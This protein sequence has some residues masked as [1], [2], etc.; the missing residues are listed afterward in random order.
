MKKRVRWPLLFFLGALSAANL[1]ATEP[2]PLL[3]DIIV[4][5]TDL[6]NHE[7]IIS[8]GRNYLRFSNGTANIGSGALHL[9]G[10]FP[11]T[12]EG[13]QVV[14][15]RVFVGDDTFFD[16]DAGF[17]VFHP[18]HSHIHIEDW[19]RYRLREV[20]PDG[21][22]GPIIRE[23]GK[24]SFCI[25]DLAIYDST[26]PGFARRGQYRSCGSTIQG[27]SVGWI[28]IY[29][30]E[31]P[32]QNIEITDLP[33]GFYWLESEVDPENNI[34]ESDDDNN[35]A[36]IQVT[37]G[38]PPSPPDSYEPN[39]TLESVD[40][41]PPG[42]PNSSNLGPTN[43]KRVLRDMSIHE[44]GDEDYFKF[45]INHRGS[46]GDFVR[47]DFSNSSGNLGL[48]LLNAEGNLLGLSDRN[49]HFETIALTGMEEGWY[50]A[51]VFSASGATNA[52]YM[53]TVVPPQNKAPSVTLI[54]PP[55]GDTRLVHGTD[56][57]AVTWDYSDEEGNLAWVNVY[58]NTEPTF[59]GN[60]V[61]L[62]TALFT[63]AEHGLAVVNS[64]ELEPQTYW[65]YGEI[66]DGGSTTGAW[67]EGT[68]TFVELDD[69][70]SAN[71]FSAEDCNGNSLRDSC[72]IESG[73][74]TDCNWNGL[75]D[76]C[77]IEQG[78][79]VDVDGNGLADECEGP[80]FHR[81][82]TNHDGDVDVADASHLFNFLFLT[83][84][85]PTCMEAADC[86]N[87]SQ[88]DLTDGI[89]ILDFLFLGSSLLAAPGPTPLPC[90]PDPD[91][92]GEA[93]DLGCE[94]YERC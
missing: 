70:C 4:R 13:K 83:G 66:T 39:N 89:L 11:E 26:L 33:D 94:L 85:S 59:D 2:E 52:N 82:D 64:A 16:I 77:D 50:F 35:I 88:V 81:G 17:F 49:G 21:G 42:L 44:I 91:P 74:R 36:R 27:L 84:R 54:T 47:I 25:L 22:V 87:S 8:S 51:R 65:V 79:F 7:T 10:V 5:S 69:T 30:K 31:L 29:A 56:L 86:D 78:L 46:G 34:M 55:P 37:I 28:D 90:G 1:S 48:A 6:F 60:E 67:S 3:P 32:G 72:E 73:L 24:V 76:E 68:V 61:L 15:Q 38:N 45:Y 41:L 43:P 18:A 63:E 23:S 93:G 40:G 19:C 12:D 75:P 57:Y 58:L 92:A 20:L 80:Q 62:S 71:V 14:R 53:L 9:F